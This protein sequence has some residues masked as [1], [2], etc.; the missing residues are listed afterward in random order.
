MIRRNPSRAKAKYGPQEAGPM[1][2]P[3]TNYQPG[4]SGGSSPRASTDPRMAASLAPDAVARVLDE[5]LAAVASART[6]DELKAVRIA[7][8]GDRAPLSLASA[9]LGALPPEPRAEAGR[10]AG[11]ARRPLPPPLPH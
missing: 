1:S 7:H 11:R 4:G 9:E 8:D 6:L 10:R 3:N 5:A 2:A